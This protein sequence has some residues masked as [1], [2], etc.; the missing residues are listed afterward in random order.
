MRNIYMDI[1]DGTE[2][3]R[4]GDHIASVGKKGIGTVYLVQVSRLV[5]RRDP[6]AP[7]R[8]QMEVEVVGRDHACHGRWYEFTWY[9]RKKRRQTFE[10]YMRRTVNVR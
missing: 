1:L 5:K 3:P 8:Y 4:P 7:P 6:E 10:Q 2:G 9:P